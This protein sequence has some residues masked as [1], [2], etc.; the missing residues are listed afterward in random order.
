MGFLFEAPE[1]SAAT[2]A[3]MPL[4]SAANDV[5]VVDVAETAA[6]VE[7]FLMAAVTYLTPAGQPSV[8][9]PKLASFLQCCRSSP[10]YRAPPPPPP[11]QYTHS[12]RCWWPPALDKNRDIALSLQ[13]DL[14]CSGEKINDRLLLASHAF[15]ARVLTAAALC[16]VCVA[17]P[18]LLYTPF[19]H[20]GI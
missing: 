4:H 2:A 16:C 8:C 15:V 10:P 7:G 13:R 3:K 18:S 1:E 5:V 9:S 17:T 6:A 11:L 20:V 12:P 14:C 19:T